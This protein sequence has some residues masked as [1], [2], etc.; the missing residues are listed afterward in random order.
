[1]PQNGT[2]FRFIGKPK[3][4]NTIHCLCCLF[5]LFFLV[6]GTVNAEMIH[7]DFSG[8]KFLVY[9]AGGGVEWSLNKLGINPENNQMTMLEYGAPVTRKLLQDHHILIVASHLGKFNSGLNSSLIEECIDGRI[10]LSGHDTDWHVGWEYQAVRDTAERLLSQSISYI[11]EGNGVGMLAF[12]DYNA[13]FAFDWLPPA[14]GIEVESG[15]WEIVT[16]ITGEGQNS[17]VYEGISTSDLSYWAISFHT[18]FP[19]FGPGFLPFEMGNDTPT[20]ALDSDGMGGPP[21]GPPIE[22]SQNHVITIATPINAFERVIWDVRD[23]KNALFS[24]SFSGILCDL[25]LTDDADGYVSSSTDLVTPDNIWAME[26]Y[27][28]KLYMGVGDGLYDPAVSVDEIINDVTVAALGAPVFAAT[29]EDEVISL[30]T[31]NRMSTDKSALFIGTGFEASTNDTYSSTADKIHIYDGTD[32]VTMS[33]GINSS[34]IQCFLETSNL[35]PE[36]TGITLDVLARIEKGAD[37]SFEGIL[38][39]DTVWSDQ[40]ALNDGIEYT[41]TYDPIGNLSTAVGMVMTARLPDGAEY[42]SNSGTVAGVYDSDSHSVI[43]IPSETS[44]GQY[45]V[46]MVLNE[47]TSIPGGSLDI[48]CWVENA[49]YTLSYEDKSVNVACWPGSV[50]FVDRDN[51]SGDENGTSWKTAFTTIEEALGHAEKSGCSSYNEIWV[52]EGLYDTES[53]IHLVSGID[54]YGGFAGH[55]SSLSDRDLSDSRNETRL[56]GDGCDYVVIGEDVIIDGFIMRGGAVGGISCNNTSPAIINCN[57][58][59]NGSG[60]SGD[61]GV[62]CSGSASPILL[63]NFIVANDGDGISITGTSTPKMRNVTIV[64]N[65]GLGI[66]ETGSGAET[67][68]NCILWNNNGGTTNLQYIGSTL[69][70]CYV[71]DFVETPDVNNNFGGPDPFETEQYYLD[72]DSDCIDE[73]YSGF[74]AGDPLYI[75]DDD[76]GDDETDILGKIRIVNDQIDIGAYEFPVL[77][78]DAGIDRTETMIS[79]PYEVDIDADVIFNNTQGTPPAGLYLEWTR[80]DTEPGNVNITGIHT[81]DPRMSFDTYGNYTFE[82]AAYTDSS[83]SLLIDKDTVRVRINLGIAPESTKTS[84]TLPDKTFDLS[85]TY[86]GGTPDKIEWFALEG[87]TFSQ[88]GTNNSGRINDDESTTVTV[89]DQPDFYV[90]RV[91]AYD[92][93]GDFMGDAFIAIPVS[94]QMLDVTIESDAEILMTEEADYEITWPDNTVNLT[95]TF[96]GGIPA[97]ITWLAPLGAEDLMWFGNGSEQ[98]PVQNLNSPQITATFLSPNTI[99]EIGLE[100][101]DSDGNPVGFGTVKI[102]VNPPT[103]NSLVVVDA[104]DDQA[105]SWPQNF[106]FLSGD[107]I[108]GALGTDYTKLKWYGPME[109]EGTPV[110][111]TFDDGV[112]GNEPD[113]DVLDTKVT[114]NAVFPGNGDY[115][116]ELHAINEIAGVDYHVGTANVTITVDSF[117]SPRDNTIT[118]N[119]GSY[120]NVHLDVTGEVTV[121][122]NGSIVDPCNLHNSTKT[123]WVCYSDPASYSF[124]PDP[125][126]GTLSP[127]ITF[128]TQGPHVVALIAKDDSD[129]TLLTA[130]TTI[131]VMSYQN[132]DIDVTLEA[133]RPDGTPAQEPIALTLFS[134][135]TLELIA[136]V[137]SEISVWSG[138]SESTGNV[139]FTDVTYPIN[140]DPFSTATVKFHNTGI[141]T[142]KFEIKTDQDGTVVGSKSITVQVDSPTGLVTA[143]AGD[144]E[145]TEIEGP[146]GVVYANELVKVCLDGNIEFGNVDTYYWSCIEYSVSDPGTNAPLIADENSG[147]VGASVSIYGPGTYV[148][149]LDAYLGPN[150]IDSD[151][152]IVEVLSGEPRVYAGLNYPGVKT[153][154]PLTLVQAYI[155]DDSTIENNNITW[156]CSPSNGVSFD[157]TTL[158][159]PT[160]TFT[161][162]NVYELTLTYFDGVYPSV[163]HSVNIAVNVAADIYAG[164]DKETVAFIP[165][166]LDDA[167]VSPTYF[168]IDINPKWTIASGIPGADYKFVKFEPS[169]S[170]LNPTVTFLKQV[171][172]ETIIQLQLTVNDSEYPYDS[173]IG[174]NVI[175]ISVFNNPTQEGIVPLITDATVNGQD[176]S[177][178]S[179]QC[180]YLAIEVTASDDHMESLYLELDGETLT[181][182]K[183]LNYNLELLEGL[184]ETPRKLKLSCLLNSHSLSTGSHTLKALAVDKSGNVA[185][186]T[187]TFSNLCLITDFYVSPTV[188]ESGQETLTFYAQ[189]DAAITSWVMEVFEADDESMTSP[190]KTDSD[191]TGDIESGGLAI[192]FTG[193]Q[194]GSYKARLTDTTAGGTEEAFVYFDISIGWNSVDFMVSLADEIKVNY[195]GGI[196]LAP[197]FIISNSDFD[198]QGKAYHP[199]YYPDITVN[200]AVLSEIYYKVTISSA[201]VPSTNVTSGP[202]DSDGY[203]NVSVGSSSGNGTLTILDLSSFENGIYTITLKAICNGHTKTDS[204]QIIL[205]CPLKLGQVKF[206]QEDM[207]I[208]VG[209]YPIQVIRSYDSFVKDK[210]GDF[211]YGWNYSLTNLDID[212]DE[213]RIDKGGYTERQGDTYRRDV[214]MTLPNGKRVT[215]ASSYRK[216]N[217]SPYGDAYTRFYLEYSYPTDVGISNFEAHGTHTMVAVPDPQPHMYWEGSDPLK[218]D[219]IPYENYAMTI[220]DVP[221]YTL[222]MNDGTTYNITR[223]SYG[224]KSVEVPWMDWLY[225]DETVPIFSYTPYGKPYLSSIDFANGDII[226]FEIDIEDGVDADE[227]PENPIVTGIRYL[228]NGIVPGTS[229]ID[230]EWDDN[231]RII[232]VNAPSETGQKR[233]TGTPTVKYYYEDSNN[234]IQDNGNLIRVEKL[235][236]ANGPGVSDD[237]YE[238]TYY[239]YENGMYHPDDHY[240]TEIRDPRGLSPIRYLYD[241]SGKLTGTMDAKDNIIEI[242]HDATGNTETVID[243]LGNP[244]IYQYN[245]RG[246][247]VSVT[248]AQ[249]ETVYGYGDVIVDYDGDTIETLTNSYMDGPSM[250][251]GPDGNTTYH[252]YDYV[253]RALKTIDPELNIT[254]NTYS[255][256]GNLLTSTQYYIPEPAT[257]LNTVEISTTENVYSSSNMLIFTG[258]RQ[259]TTWYSMNLNYYDGQNRLIDSVQVNMDDT[260]YDTLNEVCTMSGTTG[261]LVDIANLAAV[262]ATPHVITSYTYERDG[263]GTPPDPP[264]IS[265]V[266]YDPYPG[267]PYCVIDP[268]GIR[269]YSEY[270]ANGNQIYSYRL[271]D[272]PIGTDD[273]YIINENIYDAQGRVIE[274]HR[275]IDDDTD[276]TNGVDSDIPQSYTKYNSIGKVEYTIGFANDSK[277]EYFYDETGNTVETWS[278]ILEFNDPANKSASTITNEQ[279][280]TASRTLYDNAGRTIVSVGPYA[281]DSSGDPIEP[282]IGTE[283]V[284]DAVGRVVETRRWENVEILF[285]AS[286]AAN[287]ETIVSV[288][289]TLLAENASASTP[290]NLAWTSDGKTPVVASTINDPD[291]QI[292]PM[293]YSRSIYDVAGRTAHSVVLD[294]SG[295][296]Q[297]TSYEYDFAGKQ[298]AVIDPDGHKLDDTANDLYDRNATGDQETDIA[299]SDGTVTA[300]RI[301]FSRFDYNTYAGAGTTG[302]FTGTHTTVTAYEGTRR[303]AVMDANGNVTS[304]TYDDLG[305]V[306]QTTYPLVELDGDSQIDD[307]TYTHVIYDGLG[308]KVLESAQTRQTDP[309]HID[310][311]VNDLEDFML[312][313]KEY[314]YDTVG[315]LIQVVLPIPEDG[316]ANPIYRYY[317]GQYGNQ[318]AILDP[319]G[320]VTLF[321]Y[322]HMNRQTIKYM[323]YE[324]SAATSLDL[325]DRAVYPVFDDIEGDLP[326]NQKYQ[327][328]FYDDSNG[329][330]VFK[331]KDYKDQ[332]T[333]YYYYGT[334]VS[335]EDGVGNFLGKPGQLCYKHSYITDPQSD[336]VSKPV[337]SGATPDSEF[338][339]TYDKLGRQDIVTF[340]DDV[341]YYEY[342]AQGRVE[343]IDSPEGIINYDYDP[344][345]GRKTATWTGTTP[346]SPITR[347][348]YT[349][350]VM[351]R[352]YE[353]ILTHRDST[354]ITDEVTAYDYTDVGSRNSVTLDNGV[355]TKYTYNEQN[356]LSDVFNY[357]DD[358]PGTVLSSFAYSLNANGM[359]AGVNE[360]FDPADDSKNHDIIYGYDNLNRLTSESNYNSDASGYGY[361]AKYTYDLTGNRL[362]RQVKVKNSVDTTTLTTDYT[363]YPGTDKLHTEIHI[364][365]EIFAALPW[366]DDQQVYAF[367]DGGG[368][369]NYKLPGTSGRTGQLGAFIRGLPSAF[370]AYLFY[371]LAGLFGVLA[372]WPVPAGLWYRLRF[373]Y[374][375]KRRVRGV[376]IRQFICIF[377]ALVFLIGP[378]CLIRLSEASTQYSQI[379]TLAWGAVGDTITY[380]Y[381]DNGS[382]TSKT[383]AV[384]GGADTEVVDYTYNLQNRLSRVVTDSTPA[385]TADAVSITEYTYNTS[386]IRTGKYSYDTDDGGTTRTNEAVTDY[387]IDPSNHTGYA[388]VLEE[389]VDSNLETTYT[390]GDDVIAQYNSTDGTEYLLYDGHGSTRQL[391]DSTGSIV[392]DP[393]HGEQSFSYDG[394]GVMLGD[395]ANAESTAS[396]SHLYAGEQY[397]ASASVYYNRAR[398]YNQSNGTFNRVDPYS[399]NTQDPQSLHK[400]A[401]CHNNPINGIDPTGLWSLVGAMSVV[402]ITSS[403]L[404]MALPIVGGVISAAKANISPWAY[405]GELASL[406][407]WQNAFFA[408]GLGAITGTVLLKLAGKLGAKM[409]S[410]VGALFSV[411]GLIN[412]IGLTKNMISGNVSSQDVVR[413]LAF[414][415]AVVILSVIIGRMMRAHESGGLPGSGPPPKEP[416]IYEFQG[417]SEKLYVGGSNNLLRRMNEHI[418][419]GKLAPE[420]V[421][422]LRWRK[423]SGAK[424]DSIRVAE[425]LRID[426]RGGTDALE[427]V[428]NSIA[429]GNRGKFGI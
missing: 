308:R 384:T 73:G 212:L 361:H 48:F 382:L 236:N 402:S 216:P 413:Y 167:Y 334:D 416:G 53:G 56:V 339:Y 94:H 22:G 196:A 407:T 326:T 344:I 284:Y 287:G 159:N 297:V 208:T 173:P 385:N 234:G 379:N 33:D 336:D 218:T 113:D 380:E 303:I 150:Y 261:T 376:V 143:L 156:S 68:Y 405:F 421:K 204:T 209:G 289:D 217:L 87:G 135:D 338:Y 171:T 20:Y 63:N 282:A 175:E 115:V 54:M 187:A 186:E 104:G 13:A 381:D 265:G 138:W 194:D 65:T 281:C 177:S 127:T 85:A 125:A 214:A 332:V 128:K 375:P 9:D 247:V 258:M 81:V 195:D 388:Q 373:G 377:M 235:V 200:N 121:D 320:R 140:A 10:I 96:D 242:Q 180:G 423:M 152:V 203:K 55:E 83:K 66:N 130:T 238:A 271:W 227:D 292:G 266:S 211:G 251:Q 296:E 279:L 139:E 72:S 426:A 107:I 176:F 315:R 389:W 341:T 49:D 291:T 8:Y 374:W 392:I 229:V 41:I 191:G 409:F 168:G 23:Y 7:P 240:V 391:A 351:G 144:C 146:Y 151:E 60:V 162:A 58:T 363:Y 44:S 185:T 164:T 174:D 348:E 397:D 427:N 230:I 132:N 275:I 220:H 418:R 179:E 357:E 103:Y 414:T 340:D 1:M 250:V 160:V 226:D 207:S 290:V 119:A 91:V 364:D 378:E 46:E 269:Q 394:Y 118:V 335:I 302:N 147:D 350:D 278:Y 80:T 254:E 228:Q 69:N 2:R 360:I 372:L 16:E 136:T 148:F 429:R 330:R 325:T 244:T 347:T 312:N 35:K 32:I 411:W 314:Y 59:L 288:S 353:T 307:L 328:Q 93:Q 77:Q 154:T 71:Q 323:P 343:S 126:I 359:R 274:T 400:Y 17:G 260:S 310:D 193:V 123:E 313:Y 306:I 415:T 215:F 142:I 249:G 166:E 163:S 301:D 222:T 333:Y 39:N 243:R 74:L 92:L 15:S 210:E 213:T 182:D 183:F 97:S 47:D 262:V 105:I 304:F 366:K 4:K 37:G 316:M 305:R 114:F 117:G 355:Y 45:V 157:D 192:D 404:S 352:L 78:V 259:G 345:T 51:D 124:D 170:V 108:K 42:V 199:D 253:G 21:F 95:A 309:D 277:T 221:G 5:V 428:V 283:T 109:A 6:A 178:V 252:Q 201:D 369:F 110:N 61:V 112:S 346:A 362:K 285:S 368:G 383:T 165:V 90:F 181:Q 198:L 36:P 408:I 86:I 396:T 19:S 299:L 241:N 137:D 172:E 26:V 197:M 18:Y 99:Y 393:T 190:V 145:T 403:M 233:D 14:W 133:N 188:A 367:S 401:Y 237:E 161:N 155:L 169:D 232:A 329:G 88:S 141:Y 122:L 40:Y 25:L 317:Y 420:N 356:R 321:E 62:S 158:V 354:D 223:H 30:M 270:D 224:P 319:L 337:L 425:Q 342:D 422:T 268:T 106:A 100:A 225:D 294:E 219:Y 246:N 75:D 64:N 255:S 84:V 76:I 131:D 57:I 311:L 248:N 38:V 149:K 417:K 322:D 31:A 386:D 264:Y 102:K 267:Q 79:N 263:D 358:T 295:V 129:T 412:S 34:G 272:D 153:N 293:S 256:S 43:W 82:L 50:I 280:L 349:Y 120:S 318:T 3:M 398:Y 370:D 419:S 371:G 365:T 205:N 189:F 390:L 29:G 134:D 324:S 387:L 239:E 70:Y 327:Q 52:A 231:G 28:D 98:S 331:S 184:S 206:S 257:P 276:L 27:Q 89:P 273:K 406:T 395:A 111:I 399:G 202:L 24:G 116:F 424:L 300:S 67:I 286:I 12:T 11:L 410:I 245:D 101:K 298:T